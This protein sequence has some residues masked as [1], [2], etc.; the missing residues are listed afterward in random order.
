HMDEIGLMIRH[1]DKKG[2]LR[3]APVGGWNPQILPA[4]RVLIRT[5]NGNIIRGVVGVKPP[6]ILDPKEKEKVIPLDNLFIDI[7]VSSKEEAEKLGITVGSI[8]VIDRSVEK[9]GNPDFV[10]GRAFDDKVGVI[11]AVE[12]FKMINNQ[13]VDV[14]LVITVQ[15]EVGLKGAKTAAYSIGPDIG[16]ALDVTVAAD[17]PGVPEQDQIVCLG[18]GPAIKIMD[19]KSGSGIIV[20]PSVRDLLIETARSENIPY[21]L[22]ILPGGTTDASAIQLTKEGVPTGA[23]SI[24]TRYIHSPA[25]IVNLNDVVNAIR[26][27]AAFTQRL[28]RDWIKTNLKTQIK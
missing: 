3:F 19:G 11:T 20:H 5:L 1:I 9:L 10:T 12:A 8:A 28:H 26:L 22:E 7:G 25:E 14:Y 23:I 17:V 2:F 6:H 18:K 13:K 24:P 15:E 16:I 27:L 4:Q 21:Q